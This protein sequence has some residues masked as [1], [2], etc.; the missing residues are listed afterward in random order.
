[1]WKNALQY[2]VLTLLVVAITFTFVRQSNISKSEADAM[3]K[4]LAQIRGALDRL[5]KKLGTK[6]ENRQAQIS[7][8]DRPVLGKN[9]API[10]IVELSDYECP[11]C[12][13]FAGST[14]VD[15]KKLY[16][17]SGKVRLVYKDL[18]LP[19]HK[20]AK[21][22]AQAA[23]CAGDQGKYWPMHDTLFA[24][25]K[26]YA[27][28]DLLD[29]AK[30]LQLN[31][32]EFESCINSDRHMAAIEQDLKD[33]GEAGF[34]GT[35]SFVIGKT[36]DDIIKGDVVIGARPLNSFKEIIEKLL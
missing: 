13:R 19:F 31:V 27:K 25:M 22:A 9:T 17:D 3:R 20:Q 4:E 18:P 15:L 34:T 36:T 26:K 33:A 24:N 29:Y 23:H 5:E 11:Y 16:I 8:K 28:P 32:D 6:G 7:T 12:K 35:P 1:M 2:F 14:L 10:T 21:P 30:Q